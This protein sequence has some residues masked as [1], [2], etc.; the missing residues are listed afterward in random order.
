MLPIFDSRI[1]IL[2]NKFIANC[3][4]GKTISFNQK[5]AAIKMLNRGNCRNCSRKYTQIINNNIN[6]YKRDDNRWCCACSGCG[7]EQAYTRKDHAKQSFLS[8]WQCKKC[9]AE[10][11]LFNNNKPVGDKT[12]TYNK[13]KKSAYSR[14]IE[15]SLTEVQMFDSF[16]GKCALS[17]WPIEI[18]YLAH[19]AS[20]DRI[21]SSIG[22]IPSNI[23]WVHSM[24]N[25]CKNKYDENKFIEMCEAISIKKSIKKQ[26]ASQQL[27]QS[28]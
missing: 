11:K 15:W 5:S 10:S 20:V 6:I 19:T 14:G 7:E 13:F 2:N 12:R 27:T 4:C 26:I 24:V 23:Q 28:Y 25:M 17:D 8:D 18:T 3:V 1:T 21:D 22:Y 9:V 16:N